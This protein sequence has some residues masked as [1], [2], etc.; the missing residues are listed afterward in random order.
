M[1]GRDASRG[2][3]HA[4]TILVFAGVALPVSARS[5]G[6]AGT[7]GGSRVGGSEAPPGAGVKSQHDGTGFTHGQCAAQRLS[8]QSWDLHHCVIPE[9]LRHPEEPPH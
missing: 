6:W 7:L 4:A 2:D 9:G 3:D 1:T 8:G 5:G